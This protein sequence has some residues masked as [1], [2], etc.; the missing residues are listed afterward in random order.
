MTRW[1]T[2]SAALLALLAGCTDPDSTCDEGQVRCQGQ[3][4]GT[5]EGLESRDPF[6][7]TRYDWFE[8][9]CAAEGLECVVDGP[10]ADCVSAAEP[11]DPA[12]FESA[13]VEGN[14]LVCTRLADAGDQRSPR[15]WPVL[16]DCLIRGWSCIIGSTGRA[17]C[18][19]PGGRSCDRLNSVTCTAEGVLYC[20][21]NGA[22]ITS[23]CGD[24]MGGDLC[25]E[26]HADAFCVLDDTPCDPEAEADRCNE[27]GTAVI[28]C[29]PATDEDP[30]MGY[31]RLS[32]CGDD[33]ACVDG[34]C[35]LE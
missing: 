28:Y 25:V 29:D 16:D 24:V 19:E 6:T 8:R 2:A 10:I 4:A 22:G 5:C 14:A 7:P 26:T 17:S 15:A 20:D 33:I 9:D 18:I 12:T 30:R 32:T 13:C 3:I 34:G 1:V 31:R 27:A 11:C 35:A 21:E 23:A